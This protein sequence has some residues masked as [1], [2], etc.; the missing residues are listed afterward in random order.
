M[1]TPQDLEFISTHP[2]LSA[3]DR[4]AVLT[5]LAGPSR[6]SGSGGDGGHT[7]VSS[8]QGVSIQRA[9]APRGGRIY[10]VFGS[11]VVDAP[12]AVRWEGV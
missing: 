12:A 7:K 10:R 6:G 3:A 4:R 1:A 9:A 11:G 5:L 2:L 8:V